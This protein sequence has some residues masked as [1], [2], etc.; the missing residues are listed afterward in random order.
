MVGPG[1]V[2]EPVEPP[3]LTAEDDLPPPQPA[4]SSTAL[5][6]VVTRCCGR[7]DAMAF[8]VALSRP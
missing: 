4:R 3:S 7:C 1:P 2:S 5:T 6:I 8:N